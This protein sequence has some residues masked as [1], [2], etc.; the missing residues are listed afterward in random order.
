MG[1]AQDKEGTVPIVTPS[2][3]QELGDFSTAMPR[4]GAP[5]RCHGERKPPS[6]DK[7]WWMW[8]FP[9]T[10]GEKPRFRT[11]R[12][13]EP[14]VGAEA[15]IKDKDERKTQIPKAWLCSA[16]CWNLS[17]GKHLFIC[18]FFQ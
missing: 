14:M 15:E 12:G 4:P 2:A 7:D 6:W 9:L 3:Q 13:I 5:Q 17:I 8:K 11:S 10:G 16:S 18:S 1:S